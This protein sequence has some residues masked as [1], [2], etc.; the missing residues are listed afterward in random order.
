MHTKFA[1]SASVLKKEKKNPA[2]QTRALRPEFIHNHELLNQ[3]KLLT[4]SW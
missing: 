3:G 4:D 1:N 2:N